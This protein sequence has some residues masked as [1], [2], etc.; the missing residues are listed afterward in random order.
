[1]EALAGGTMPQDPIRVSEPCRNCAVDA[2]APQVSVYHISNMDCP[3]EE[4][5]IRG[6]LQGLPGVSALGFNLVNRGPTV[7]HTLPSPEPI[8]RALADIGMETESVT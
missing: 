8:A 2:A 1:M 6:K 7:T 4:G 3:T 5:L